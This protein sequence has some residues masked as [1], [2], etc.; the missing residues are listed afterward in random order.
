MIKRFWNKKLTALVKKYKTLFIL[1]MVGDFENT[2]FVSI[3]K[4]IHDIGVFEPHF[5][6][7]LAENV[8]IIVQSNYIFLASK[9]QMLQEDCRESINSILPKINH[10]PDVD[11]DLMEWHRKIISRKHSLEDTS[12][13]ILAMVSQLAKARF[14]EAEKTYYENF[15]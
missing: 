5:M 1:L 8:D 10:V 14:K 15:N 4:E 7:Y 11:F 12:M 9:S 6:I 3:L 13:F 2:D